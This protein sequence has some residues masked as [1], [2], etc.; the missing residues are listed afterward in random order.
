MRKWKKAIL[1]VLMIVLTAVWVKA[2]DPGQFLF[3][4]YE[5]LFYHSAR[6]EDSFPS[7]NFIG[8]AISQFEQALGLDETASEAN[9]MLG[10][11]YQF[12]DRPGTA[13]GYYLEY[14]ER[15]PEER[16]INSLIGDLYLEMG[17]GHDACTFYEKALAEGEGDL[18]Q[19]HLGLGHLAY[20]QGDYKEAQAAYERALENAGD[21]F[22]ARLS[23]GKTLYQMGDYE[24]AVSVL[25]QAQLQ[26]PRHAP[27]Y[28]YLA[29]SYEAAGLLDQ[30]E[31]ALRRVQELK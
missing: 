11:V 30:A 7:V 17:R 26:A 9:L 10:L 2:E 14:A 19:A 6:L 20:E 13:L 27:L 28:H 29:L 1:I 3:N 25:E 4:G 16:W 31:H 5:A 22:E 23:L 24:E 8:L 18:A 12:L 21:Y 15:N